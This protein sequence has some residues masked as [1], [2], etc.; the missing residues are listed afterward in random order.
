MSAVRDV[1]V[2]AAVVILIAGSACSRESRQAGSGAADGEQ[3]AAA[4]EQPAAPE[5]EDIPVEEVPFD[6]ANFS[7]SAVVDNQWFPL[8][9]GTRFIYEGTAQD[10]TDRIQRSVVFTVTD[11]TKVVNGV[12]TVVGWDRDY[13]DG[14]LEE[15]EI[16]F[17]AQDRAGN[18]WHFGQV[19]EVYD[20]EGAYVG[21]SVWLAGLE[22]A[23]P[24]V[25]MRADPQ[26]GAPAHSQGFA[27]PPFFWD[28]A[29]RV[30][31]SG[32]KTCVTAGCYDNVLVIDE[33]ERAKPGAHQLKYYAP[34]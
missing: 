20:E 23:K 19:V 17:L 6:P 15:S 32:E 7:D 13:N 33:F 4:D 31:A 28:D 2:A 24:G 16:I 21:T 25:L 3:A 11:L 27:P 26:K 22:G 29:A 18:V 30:H 14:N 1:L 5:L 12:R 34:G 9:P 10:E 8:K